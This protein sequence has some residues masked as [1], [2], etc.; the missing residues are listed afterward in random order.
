MNRVNDEVTLKI[1]GVAS[2]AD[3]RRLR[4]ASDSLSSVQSSYRL[5]EWWHF[6]AKIVFVQKETKKLNIR[7]NVKDVTC[8]SLLSHSQ[9]IIYCTYFIKRYFYYIYII[10]PYI[11]L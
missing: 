9:R 11:S 3:R 8:Y 2:E 7:K 1:V 10:S 4:G 5:F 6:F